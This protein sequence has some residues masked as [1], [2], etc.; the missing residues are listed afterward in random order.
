M[1]REKAFCW[2]PNCNEEIEIQICCNAYDCGCQGLPVDPPFCSE[3]C[4]NAYMNKRDE[5]EKPTGLDFGIG[6]NG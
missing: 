1:P 4:Y 2:G 5:P 3:E 6:I